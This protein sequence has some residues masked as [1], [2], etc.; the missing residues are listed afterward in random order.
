VSVS[1][2]E[3]NFIKVRLWV[4]I[5]DNKAFGIIRSD[6]YKRILEEFAKEGI[7]F[8]VPRREVRTVTGNAEGD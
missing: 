7:E 6:L 1:D 3:E 8:P 4:T 5:S 2:I